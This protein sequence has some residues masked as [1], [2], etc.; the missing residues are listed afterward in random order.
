VREHR[1]RRR[2]VHQPSRVLKPLDCQLS[3]TIFSNTESYYGEYNKNGEMDHYNMVR[4][5][6][7]NFPASFKIS[8][9][10]HADDKYDYGN[11]HKC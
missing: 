11:I 9:E 2:R 3:H 4:S 1:Y 8:N 6:H 5:W 7:A 10:S